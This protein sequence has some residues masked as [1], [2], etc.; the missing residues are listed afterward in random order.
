L[1]IGY[2][3]FTALH[4]GRD[5]CSAIAMS[6]L[7]NFFE[8]NKR[9]T[10]WKTEA[11]AG[12]TI[13]MAMAYIIFAN[14]AILQAAGVP[15]QGAVISTCIAAGI[16]SIMMGLLTN[17]PLCMAAGMGLNAVVAFTLVKAMGLTWQTAMGVVVLEGLVV[18]LL[19]ASALRSAVMDA[20][21]TSL[22]HAIAGAIGL[23]ITFIGL[24]NGNFIKSHPATM[25][26]FEDF[27][28]PVTLLSSIGFLLSA[29]LIAAKIRGALLLGIV[30]TAIIGML[31]VWPTE[32]DG[33]GS[34]IGIPTTLV[35]WPR[36][37]STFFQFDLTGALKWQL[38]PVA[39]A[40]LMTDFF[41]TLGSAL[42][43]VTKA[44]LL[45]EDGRIPR[46][47]RLLVVDSVGAVLG[48]VAGCSSNTSY[49]ES[50]AGV[51]EGGRTG[52]AAIVCGI[53]FLG[54]IF[55]V[56]L[57]AVVGGG[58][59]V[60]PGTFKNPVTAGSLILVGFFMIDSIRYIRWDD[61]EESLAA[62]IILVVTPFTFSI[63]HGIGAGIIMYVMLLVLRGK[64]RQVPPLLW[65]T[66]GLFSLV[67]LL[68]LVEP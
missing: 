50:A 65:I 49:V 45:D 37:W 14:P 46:L 61:I 60:A 25:L 17:Y 63:T 5:C 36:D 19:S 3:K 28:N 44:D 41:D 58:V 10:S 11:R 4:I 7:T 32:T 26:T 24:Q 1:L 42:A 27:T 43:V 12:I 38:I 40:L 62:F 67:F 64:A 54:S 34:L 31:P 6:W 16:M 52:F 66:A 55:L 23:F 9:N 53:L 56:P 57:V 15:F 35:Q 30:G 2:F 47:K 68:P 22:K 13:F 21:P 48:G 20:I 33:R 29:T 8:I 59:E 39:F 51:S 18:L